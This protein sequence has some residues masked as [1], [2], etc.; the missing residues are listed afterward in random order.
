MEIRFIDI[1][2]L[3]PMS[4]NGAELYN[5]MC[6]GIAKAFGKEQQMYIMR[7]KPF[8]F[9]YMTLALCKTYLESYNFSLGA[10]HSLGIDTS[11]DKVV[12]ALADTHKAMMHKICAVSPQFKDVIAHYRFNLNGDIVLF[13]NCSLRERDIIFEYIPRSYFSK[14]LLSCETGCDMH[15]MDIISDTACELTHTIM[16]PIRLTSPYFGGGSGF[17]KELQPVLADKEV[18][19]QELARSIL[20]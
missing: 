8:Q 10:M 2:W 14:V 1:A 4:Y 18:I 20:Y 3:L 15:D 12:K 5:K 19:E 6:Y 7:D 13:G 17:S 11:D 16:S 9:S